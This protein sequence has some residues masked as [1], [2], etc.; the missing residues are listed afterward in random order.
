VESVYNIYES[1]FNLNRSLLG[2]NNE[3]ALNLIKKV[4]PLKIHKFKSG[5]ECFDWKIPQE[6]IL[7]KAT[8]KNIKGDIVLDVKNNILHVVNCSDS[9]NGVVKK[10]DLIKH[11]FFD[12]NLPD[13]I[14]YR[15]SYYNKNWGFCMSYNQ[16]L[17]LKD[18]EYVVEIESEFIDSFLSVGEVKLKGNTNKEIILTSYICHP[19]QANDGLSGVI[20]LLDL[21]EKLS[22][23]TDLKYTYRFFFLPETIGTIAI[24]S[25]KIIEPKNVEYALVATCVGYGKKIEYKKTFKNNH[26]LDNIVSVFFP[27]VLSKPY[28][29]YGSDER[30]FSSPFIQIPTG[31]LTR[32]QF[33]KFPEYHTSL[34]DMNFV[35]INLIKETTLFFEKLILKYEKE[36]KYIFTKD[37]GEPMLSKYKLYDVINNTVHPKSSLV[38]NWILHLSDGRHN[39]V[40]MSIKSGFNIEDISSQINILLENK[41]IKTI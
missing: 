27:E 23:L 5:E 12:E 34:D 30:Q 2:V 37:G 24:L 1:L 3:L 36:C 35:D 33:G 17:S 29:P 14:P 28:E 20:M 10:E 7:K 39:V 31:V 13:A 11:L 32:E 19:Q 9:F 21:Y 18:D 16:F 8:I 4:V 26:S 15:T 38:K 25:K 22:K 40:D 6:W 41:L